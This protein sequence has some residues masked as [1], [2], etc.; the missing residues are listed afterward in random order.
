MPRKDYRRTTGFLAL[1]GVLGLCGL[2]VGAQAPAVKESLLDQATAQIVAALLERNHLAKPKIDDEVSKRWIRNYFEALDPLKYYFL[3]ADIDEFMVEETRLDDL[4]QTGDLSFAKKVFARLLERADERYADALEILKQVPD[5]TIDESIIDDPKRLDWAETAEEARDRLRKLIKLELLQKKLEGEDLEK[6]MNQL[7]I[8]YK[9]RNRYFH[10]FDMTDLLEVYLTAMTSAVD[11]H[12]AYWGPK[13][14]EDLMGLGIQLSLEGIGASLMTEDGYP[15]V[16]EVVPGGAADKDGRLQEEDR[17]VGIIKEDGTRED[18][19]EKKLN[20]VVRKIRGPK[21]TKVKLI[22]RPAGSNEERIYELTREKIELQDEHA[23]AKVIEVPTDLR[24]QPVKVGVIQ[25]PGFYGDM[26]AVERG[27]PNAVSLTKDVRRML[28][29]FK[30]EGVE[31]V[32]LDVRGNPGGLLLEAQTLS[33]LFIDQGPIVQVREANNRRHLDD[34]DAGTAWDGPVVVAIDKGSASAAE[35]LAGVIKDYGRGLIVGDSS[36]YGKGTVQS[37]I[38]LNEQ[39]SRGNKLPNLGALKLTIQQFYRPNGESTQI[40]GVKSDIHIPSARDHADFGE[41]RNDSAVGFDKVA[42]LAHDMYNRVPPQLVAK[43]IER[44]EARRKEDPKFRED[45][46][47]IARLIER[48]KRHEIS[49]NEQ[50]FREESR[51]DEQA[52]EE[53]KAKARGRKRRGQVEAWDEKDHYNQELARI[54]ADY[55]V[56]GRQVLLAA[57]TR[58]EN[59]GEDLPTRVP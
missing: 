36:T 6:A 22:V 55:V 24:D 29:D 32:L 21:G 57:P 12:S 20:D 5:F 28:D 16:K 2:I 9:D 30:K 53:S 19:V 47:F 31:A 46:E 48:K 11:P 34:D 23:Q 27:D 43:L 3:K 50:K 59:A 4:I 49:L 41:G 26:L 45:E 54:V 14:H 8:R 13:T 38:P 7:R 10:Q 58:A 15:V 18:F 33:G 40:E 37:I 25:I 44:S 52:D 1:A 56:L 35:I 51:R 17:I 39:I 42:A